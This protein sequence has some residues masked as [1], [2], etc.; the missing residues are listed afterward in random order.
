VSVKLRLLVAMCIAAL[1]A[2]VMSA[3]AGADTSIGTTK[4]PTPIRSWS[5]V[6]AFSLYDQAA[7]A[8]RLAVSRQ[9]GA[10]ETIAVAPQPAAFDLDVGPDDA[11][12]PAIVYSR[13]TST[14]P[15]PRGCDLY[16]YSLS[17]GSE[18]KLVDASSPDA[19]ETAP[20]IWGARVAWARRSDAD[21]TVAPRIYTRTLSAPRSRRSRRL[22]GI[23]PRLCGK[24]GCVVDELELRG[25]RL[26]VNIGYPGPVCNSALVRLDVLAGRS[27]RVAQASCGLN[28]QQ[29]AGISFD[30][31]NLYF[32]RYCV[33]SPA[34]CDSGKFGAFRY[35]LRTARYS[36]ASF[37]LRLTGFSY[38][39]GGRAFEVLAPDAA[40]G[41]CGSSV[42]AP[43][44]DCQIVL[45]DPLSFA[46]ARAPLPR[47]RL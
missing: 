1:G 31:R 45:T 6:A 39:T 16:R 11:G 25:P 35:S 8:Y 23:S 15:R 12:A 33:A 3:G 19:S 26:A 4:R 17:T 14:S 13:C 44:P 7:G 2:T 28:G 47:S 43:E 36:L 24:D 42:G 5:G 27:I 37:G 32:A 46:R 30:A 20:T 18:T 29:L 9:G 40:N 38:D 10:P 34:S 22:R 21:A 41:Y